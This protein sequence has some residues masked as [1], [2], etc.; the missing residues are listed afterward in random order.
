MQ[1]SGGKA[2]YIYQVEYSLIWWKAEDEKI[3]MLLEIG[4]CLKEQSL[5][6]ATVQDSAMSHCK[7]KDPMETSKDI[8]CHA[9]YIAGLSSAALSNYLNVASY[10]YFFL[11]LNKR[12]HSQASIIFSKGKT[13]EYHNDYIAKENFNPIKP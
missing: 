5:Y 13:T 9:E 2:F 7:L 4:A 6:S 8:T 10:T 11:F 12:H 3:I 1:D